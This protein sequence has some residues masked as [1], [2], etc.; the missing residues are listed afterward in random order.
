M[1]KNP[2]Q[3]LD[4]FFT[5]FQLL[6]YRKKDTILR[7]DNVPS[8][9]FY[10]KS[11]YA[12]L[13]SVSKDG[14]EL[15]SIIF[16]PSDIFPLIWINNELP[17]SYNLEAMTPVELYR[18]PRERAI[19]FIRSNPQIFYELTDKILTRVNGLLERIEYLV[20][21][22]AYSKVAS[23]VVICA[24]RFG[25]KNGKNIIIQVPLTHKDI[26][27]LVGLTRETASIELEKLK[28]KGII[29]YRGKII[30]VKNIEKLRKESLLDSS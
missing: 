22:N 26:A 12:R 13:Y 20:F 30:V 17:H 29:D 5:K 3:K 18:V 10:F 8:E 4:D 14:Q 1:D 27:S 25:K 11:G 15:T 7:T 19:D 21:G 2:L 28:K 16:Q 9:V 23:I 24:E 6:R